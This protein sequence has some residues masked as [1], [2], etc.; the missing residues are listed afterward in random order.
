MFAQKYYDGCGHGGNFTWKEED[1]SHQRQP[2]REGAAT[3]CASLN[4]RQAYSV[5]PPL[6][7]ILMTKLGGATTNQFKNLHII[8][9]DSDENH[10]DVKQSDR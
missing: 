10:N 8:K 1:D 7:M 6:S 3:P 5:A 9:F 4:S 2:D